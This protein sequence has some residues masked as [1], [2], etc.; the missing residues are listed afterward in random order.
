MRSKKNC[1]G[2]LSFCGSSNF[3]IVENLLNAHWEYGKIIEIIDASLISKRILRVHDER[4][5][6]YINKIFRMNYVQG[7]TMML[8][9]TNNISQSAV[10][11][12]AIK[13]DNSQKAES[14]FA[15]YMDKANS[16]A[17]NSQ[18]K[19]NIDSEYNTAA[20]ESSASDNSAAPTELNKAKSSDNIEANNTEPENTE[21][22]KSKKDLL[23]E[24]A[25]FFV[26]N[27]TG[28]IENIPQVEPT[29]S[30][31]EINTDGIEGDSSLAINDLMQKIHQ[32]IKQAGETET[33]AE[34]QAVNAKLREFAAATKTELS[35]INTDTGISDSSL[36]ESTALNKDIPQINQLK[37]NKEV[38][39]TNSQ[40]TN[41]TA[42]D[43]GT[44]ISDKL[45]ISSE[46]ENKKQNIAET[47]IAELPNAANNNIQ[48]QIANQTNTKLE[49]NKDQ[50][51]TTA[52][53]ASDAAGTGTSHTNTGATRNSG[54]NQT[55]QESKQDNTQRNI[56]FELSANQ[57]E[58]GAIAGSKAESTFAEY[59]KSGTLRINDIPRYINK[60]VSTMPE[61]GSHQ[62]TLNLSSAGLGKV[63]IEI[64]LNGNMAS[65][66]F[67][68]DSTDA[69]KSI[70][71]QMS[72]LKDNLA[73]NG[74]KI[75]SVGV[76]QKNIDLSNSGNGGNN[77]PQGENSQQN[78]EKIKRDYLN[79]LRSDGEDR[80]G[81]IDLSNSES[82][83]IRGKS[84]SNNN[85]LE[86]YI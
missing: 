12:S 2:Q 11:K 50:T 13:A 26:N 77:N 16:E 63:S 25:L 31:A 66:K 65:I 58:G 29:G 34:A 6:L 84:Q 80:L 36:E 43:S 75:E 17:N 55:G 73:K 27:N 22:A 54:G 32:L 53:T 86:R 33:D 9:V 39:A 59:D 79:Y 82:L 40:L 18:E 20:A 44:T 67:K 81:N 35:S 15:N 64:S 62:A 30:K 69:V 68:A 38:N 3:F 85:S 45:S 24:I 41:I 61:N 5:K 56:A 37:I 83:P 49:I 10:H 23:S 14:A 71:S 74:I 21:E 42:P 76:E 78:Q 52:N 48:T 60:V 70:E 7:S 1:Q 51:G 4:I 8:V 46:A 57:K 47:P 72:N 28:I 19:V